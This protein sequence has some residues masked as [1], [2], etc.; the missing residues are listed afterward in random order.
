MNGTEASRTRRVAV[1]GGT[2]CGGRAVAQALR[3]A[4]H[5]VQTLSRGHIELAPDVIC[6]RRNANDLTAVL[7]SFCPEVVVDHVAYVP[8]E[9]TGLLSALPAST[10]RYVFISSAVVYGPGRDQPYVEEETPRPAGPFAA[11]KQAAEATA[12]AARSAQLEVI[13]TRLGGLYGP[14]HSPLTPWGRNTELL[15]LIRRGQTVPVPAEDRP[16]LQPW[17]SSDH[18]RFIAALVTHPN[19][20]PILNAAGE[21]ELTWADAVRAWALAIDAPPPPLVHR[22]RKDLAESA[23]ASVKPFIESL[24]DPQ[25]VQTHRLRALFPELAPFTSVAVGYRRL[26]WAMG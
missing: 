8:P 4:G 11:A 1:L 7:A 19:P 21:E 20:P 18:G 13:T 6:D 15:D 10:R 25:R 5:T 2:G 14:G 17:L 26:A 16:G 3:Q 12:L 24:L 22:D 9:V 23:P